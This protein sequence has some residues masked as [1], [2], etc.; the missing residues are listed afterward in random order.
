MLRAEVRNMITAVKELISTTYGTG[1]VLDLLAKEN[2]RL[3]EDNRRLA[4]Q[5]KQ[6]MDRLMA[7][8]F[9]SYATYTEPE[10][11]EANPFNS[12]RSSHEPIEDEQN[13]GEVVE[14]E[15]TGRE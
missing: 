11:E 4:G 13:I 5:N 2:Q 7:R 3:R 9:E 1:R 10:P 12:I 8:N 15:T 14:D 6:F